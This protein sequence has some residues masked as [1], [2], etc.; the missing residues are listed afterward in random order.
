MKL[1]PATSAFI[2]YVVDFLERVHVSEYSQGKNAHLMNISGEITPLFNR[3]YLQ[4]AQATQSRSIVAPGHALGVKGLVQQA[5]KLP[6]K[7]RQVDKTKAAF[8]LQ[9][10]EPEI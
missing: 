10:K 8:T 4:F 1:L 7:W 2:H 6:V 9:A 5:F 3:F